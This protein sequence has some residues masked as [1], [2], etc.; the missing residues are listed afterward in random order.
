M[1][2]TAG[3]ADTARDDPANAEEFSDSFDDLVDAALT[4]HERAHLSENLFNFVQY[5]FALVFPHETLVAGEYLEAFCVQLERGARGE[6]RRLIV[7]MPPRHLKSFTLVC[8]QAWVLGR[9]PTTKII[10]V[11]YGEELARSLS[12][13]FRRIV[14]SAWYRDIFP[15]MDIAPGGN[16]Q[17]EVSTTSGGYRRS[18]TVGGSLTGLGGDM[19]IAD[20]LMKGQD[21]N[22]PAM[23]ETLRHFVEHVLLGRFNRQSDGVF[24]AV[25]QR[26]H[27]EDVVVQLRE[28]RNAHVLSF[29]ARA[30]RDEAFPLY[31]GRVFERRIGDLLCPGIDTDEHLA[32]VE[33]R[34]RFV[35]A[36]Q[37]Q[38]EPEIAG[39]VMIDLREVRFV[40]RAPSRDEMIRVCQFW[41]TAAGTG[42]VNDYSVGLTFGYHEGVWY[43]FDLV[44]GRFAFPALSRMVCEYADRHRADRVYVEWASS[45]IALVQQLRAAGRPNIQ[46]RQVQGE[47]I[48]RFF[49]Q[50]G[51]LQSRDFA[52]L[53]NAAWTPIFRGEV[54][55]FPN[56]THDDIPDALSLFAAY[57][58]SSEARMDIATILNGGRR[59]RPSNP[60]RRR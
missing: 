18:A 33:L 4:A 32:E 55:N 6:Q 60:A 31:E 17:E 56:A 5:A 15:S 50:T 59:P 12:T 45:G 11:S 14:S 25:Q 30:I 41:D 22:S 49:T 2:N 8:F 43:L 37:Y 3:L 35:F 34:D 40:E 23:R 57:A 44:R 21:A 39:S 9:A 10:A 27:A 53:R 52:V 54:G 7:N 46:G 47:K 58:N 29:P 26:L 38:Q 16:R 1:T 48:V 24:I 19:I 20:D 51:F 42:D 13:L 36:A 28:L